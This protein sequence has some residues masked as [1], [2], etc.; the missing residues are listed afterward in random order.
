MSVAS[1]LKYKGKIER[2]RIM[3]SNQTWTREAVRAPHSGEHSDFPRE[4]QPWRLQKDQTSYRSWGPALSEHLSCLKAFAVTMATLAFQLCHTCFPSSQEYFCP[5]KEL[6]IS[7]NDDF[8]KLVCPQVVTQLLRWANLSHFLA[9]L[10]ECKK[11]KERRN[12]FKMAQ[13]EFHLISLGFK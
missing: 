4:C 3:L 10:Q 9:V 8:S 7:A 1:T 2:S 11:R 13:M 12:T 5:A 6:H